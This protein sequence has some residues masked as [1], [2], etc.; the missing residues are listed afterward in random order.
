MVVDVEE[1]IQFFIIL[2][3]LSY[4]AWQVHETTEGEYDF[5]GENDIFEFLHLAQKHGLLVILRPGPF[6][7]AE[8]DFGGLPSWLL[9]K[10]GIKLRTS[11]D[12]YFMASVKRWF[13]VLLPLLRPLIY[14]N[15]GPIIMMQVCQSF[16]LIIII[17]MHVFQSFWLIIAG[18]LWRGV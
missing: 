16:W 1:H 6:I 13:S 9:K 14:I 15:G 2:S 8:R 18:V 11:K 10:R 7:D 3:I 12:E 5:S 17:M 4:V